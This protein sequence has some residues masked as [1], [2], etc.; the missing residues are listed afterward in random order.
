MPR[1]VVRSAVEAVSMI[2][3]VAG[4]ATLIDQSP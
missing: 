1:M 2:L 3:Y 4:I